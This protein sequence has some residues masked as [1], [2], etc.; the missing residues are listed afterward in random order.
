VHCIL[1]FRGRFGVLAVLL[2]SGGVSR[3]DGDRL[4]H[5]GA[6]RGTRSYR[7]VHS[8]GS[9]SVDFSRSG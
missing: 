6:A 5:D 3:V 8:H 7:N 1:E 2:V 4:F 9:L